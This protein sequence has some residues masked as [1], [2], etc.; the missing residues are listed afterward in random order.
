MTGQRCCW[1]QASAQS[2][3]QPVQT[4]MSLHERFASLLLECVQ[5]TYV[6]AGALMALVR[7]ILGSAQLGC[8]GPFRCT[9]FNVGHMMPGAHV[10]IIGHWEGGLCNISGSIIPRPRSKL[11]VCKQGL[12]E[13][14]TRLWRTEAAFFAEG[15]TNTSAASFCGAANEP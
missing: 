12:S 2:S 8:C 6:A 14:T 11:F 9:R 3:G 15:S 4:V 1:H 13:V 7:L 10:A 5:H